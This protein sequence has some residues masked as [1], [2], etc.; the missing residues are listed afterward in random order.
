MATKKEVL[1]PEDFKRQLEEG[2][3]K[4]GNIVVKSDLYLMG[5]KVNGDLCLSDICVE[6][7]LGLMDTRVR[8]NLHLLNATI[9]GNLLLAGTI[10]EGEF[11]LENTTVKGEVFCGGDPA[12]AL[13]CFLFFGSKVH[14]QTSACRQVFGKLLGD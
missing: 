10:V 7:S 8:Q 2:R 3:N 13:Q 1:T 5:L 12:L 9:Q 4:F 11:F 6:G 14:L